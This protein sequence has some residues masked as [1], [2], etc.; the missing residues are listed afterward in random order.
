MEIRGKLHCNFVYDNGG[1]KV[2]EIVW[3]L[4]VFRGCREKVFFLLSFKEGRL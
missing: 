1:L 2:I 4:D 3:K